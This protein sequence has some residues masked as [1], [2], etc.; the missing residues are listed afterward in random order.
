MPRLRGISLFFAR[1]SVVAEMVELTVGLDERSYPVFIGAGILD[2]IGAD[3]ARRNIGNRY[4]IVSDSTVARLYG[5]RLQQVLANAG[6]LAELFAFPAGEESKSLTVLGDLASQLAGK[7]FDRYDAIVALG[8]GVTGD[9]AGFLAASY[10]RG[11]PFVQVPTTLLAQVDSSVG[12]KTGVDIPQGKNMV[13]AFYQPKAVYIDTDVLQSLPP[14][15]LLGGI[16]EVIKYGVI[17]DPD[18]FTFLESNIDNIISLVPEAIART[19]ETCCR[20]KA[21]VVAEDEKE[22]HVRRILNYGHTIGHA[23]EGASQYSIIHGFAVAIG[24]VAEAK[25]AVMHGLLAP[26]ENAKIVHILKSYD[27]PTEVPENLDRKEIRQYLLT[28]K[29]NVSGSILFVLPTAIGET[30]ISD[31]VTDAQIDAV[32]L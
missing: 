32:L 22:G 6:L 29:K 15:E 24:M 23:V 17:R 14:R 4:A 1:G 2:R 12:G 13:G 11:I 31:S 25:I 20:I 28:D 8:G 27:L 30:V 18:F 10:M 26:R 5:R 19:I 21:A 7:G 3:L 16:A 9:L